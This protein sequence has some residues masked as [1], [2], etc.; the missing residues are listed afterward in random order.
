MVSDSCFYSGLVR[1]ETEYKGVVQGPWRPRAVYHFIQD[2]YIRPDFI[3]D[4]SGFVEKKMGSIMAFKSQF[5]NPDSNE[6]ETPI[7]SKE[8]LEHVV[9]RMRDHGRLIGVEYGE[10]FTTERALGIEDMTTFI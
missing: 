10:G 4:V 6:P 1:I 2:R 8:F 3:V 5:Y 9:G 7:S